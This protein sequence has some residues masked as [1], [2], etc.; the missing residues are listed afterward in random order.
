VNG[1]VA[2]TDGRRYLIDTDKSVRIEREREKHRP[3]GKVL[4]E[5]QRS[6]GENRLKIVPTVPDSTDSLLCDY[7]LVT[8]AWAGYFLSKFLESPLDA[9]I[10]RLCTYFDYAQLS[11]LSKH[12]AER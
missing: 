2:P 1:S 6:V 9:R 8:A 11:H 7:A 3:A 4:F 12:L 5:E 10:E